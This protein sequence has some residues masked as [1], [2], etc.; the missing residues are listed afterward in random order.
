MPAKWT[1]KLVGKMHM[2]NIYQT[3]VAK[4]LGMSR[5]YVGLILS[6]DREPA[7]PPRFSYPLTNCIIVH[8]YLAHVIQIYLN[9]MGKSV[10]LE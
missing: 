4:E 9:Y 10:I 8:I 5:T 2:H 6:G 3:D 1:G 7:C